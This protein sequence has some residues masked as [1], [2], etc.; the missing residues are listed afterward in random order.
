M[1]PQALALGAVLGWNYQRSR[2]GKVTISQFARRHPLVTA[3][4]L[5]AGNG[6]L[7]PHLYPGLLLRRP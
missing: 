5:V 3:V 7:V 6:W 4:V 2:V 1:P